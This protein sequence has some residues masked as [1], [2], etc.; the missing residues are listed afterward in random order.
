MNRIERLV[1]DILFPDGLVC[2]VCDTETHLGFDGLCDE[3]RGKLR[4]AGEIACLPPLDGLYAGLLYDEMLHWPVHRLKYGKQ[5][6]LA[7]YL[8]QYMHIPDA[9]GRIDCLLPVPLHYRRLWKRTFNQSRLIAESLQ[10]RC[11]DVPV[12]QDLL[13]RRRNTASQ[14]NLS[15][16]ARQKN[17]QGAFVANPAVKGMRVAL[18][19]DVAT[20]SSTL[21]A[22]ALALKRA[23]AEQVFA[24]CACHAGY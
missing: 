15:R 23:G 17:V 9:W 24:V 2:F 10:A 13:K 7:R 18:V 11:P 4:T 5:T 14:T 20:T 19:D 12:R 21:A 6:W 22:C 3:C 16:A 8:A 1:G